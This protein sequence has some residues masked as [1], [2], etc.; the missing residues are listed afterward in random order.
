MARPKKPNPIFEVYFDR[1]G[2]FP[3]NIPLGSLT[4]TLSAIRRLAAGSDVPEEEEEGEE[5][6]KTPQPA[7]E[8]ALIGLVQVKRGSCAYRFAAPAA[9]TSLDHLKDAGRVLTNPENFRGEDFILRPVDL[10]SSVAR[11]LDCSILVRSTEP[12]KAVLARV[13]RDSYQRISERLFLT[14]ETAVKGYVERVGGATSRRCA[15][16][17]SFQR[18]LLFCG[19]ANNELVR[20][21]GQFLY[22]YVTVRGEARWLR[23]SWRLVELKIKSVSRQTEGTIAGAFQALRDAG[24]SAWDGVDDPKSYLEEVSGQ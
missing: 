10:L 19:V 4:T 1:P 13:D 23:N 6:E 20:Q 17:V 2:L 3:E 7:P 16:R 24:G 11:R 18:R 12:D 9:T 5:E 8:E 22:Q 14:G 15:L 21:L